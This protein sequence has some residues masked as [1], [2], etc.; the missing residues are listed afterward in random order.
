MKLIE[1]SC[2]H[3]NH[4]NAGQNISYGDR[5]I[6]CCRKCH[7]ILDLIRHENESGPYYLL[8]I[9]SVTLPKAK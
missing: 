3:K 7:K 5:R 6:I 2:G 4:P 9:A 8:C 1:C